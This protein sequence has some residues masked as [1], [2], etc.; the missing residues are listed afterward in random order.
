MEYI[1]AIEYYNA[2]DVL[3]AGD[4]LNRMASNDYPHL[5]KDARRRMHKEVRKVAEPR[6]LRV[7]LDFEDA[8]R[9]LANGR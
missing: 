8:A 5:K 1:R 2:L 9:K 4:Q 3:I 6:E 7:E